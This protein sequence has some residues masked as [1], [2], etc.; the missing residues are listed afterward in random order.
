MTPER[1]VEI[2]AVINFVVIG[3][4]HLIQ[5]RVWVEFFV[6]LRSKGYPGV[7]VNAMLSL[8]VGSIMVSFHNVWTGLAAVVTV[9]G[10]AQVVKGFVSLVAPSVGM[11]GLMRVSMERARE[12]QYA[13]I[14]FLVLS[15]VIVWGWV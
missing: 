6:V 13:G 10:W 3:L 1:S 4:S 5:P 14:M 7:F 12:F 8:L 2:F 15:A 9:I 11:K